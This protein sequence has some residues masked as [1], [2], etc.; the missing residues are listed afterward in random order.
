MH[1]VELRSTSQGHP[2]YR[3]IAQQLHR[4]ID[5]KA[6]HHAIAETMRFVDHSGSGLG[7]LESERRAE[8]RR[9]RDLNAVET[10]RAG[11]ADPV[12]NSSRDT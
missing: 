3:K 1:L 4:L 9:P 2:V 7:R 10:D 8:E 5:E 11:G 12:A 6:G